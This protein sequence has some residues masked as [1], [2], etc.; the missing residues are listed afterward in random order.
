[1]HVILLNE[2]SPLLSSVQHAEHRFPL[3]TVCRRSVNGRCGCGWRL[4]RGATFLGLAAASAAETEVTVGGVL[5]A[6]LG[7]HLRAN[8]AHLPAAVA[9]WKKVLGLS[10]HWQVVLALADR[11]AARRPGSTAACSACAKEAVKGTTALALGEVLAA[12]VLGRR[13]GA[14]FLNRGRSTRL[15]H[16]V[17]ASTGGSWTESASHRCGRED[18]TLGADQSGR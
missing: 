8:R 17:V 16:R 7:L 14:K 6:A 4:E 18:R 10:G 12:L 2:A 15:T 5:A 3:A 11:A 13:S 9:R 1:M